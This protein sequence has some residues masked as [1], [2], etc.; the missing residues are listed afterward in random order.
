MLLLSL[1]YFFS[2]STKIASSSVHSHHCSAKN[3]CRSE[4]NRTKKESI[5]EET[6]LSSSR[7]HDFSFRCFLYPFSRLTFAMIVCL[8]FLFPSLFHS[9]RHRKAAFFLMLRCIIFGQSVGAK[10]TS[11]QSQGLLVLHVFY[12]DKV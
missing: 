4:I 1:S 2:C 11:C 3:D 8:R 10:K 6:M 9:L 12:N 5:S 7:L